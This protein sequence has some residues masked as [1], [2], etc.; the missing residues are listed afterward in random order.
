MPTK[1]LLIALPTTQ[2][3]NL[4]A[5]D[6]GVPGLYEISIKDELKDQPALAAAAA[7]DAFHYRVPVKILDDFSFYVVAPGNG[8][9]IDPPDGV[10]GY[11][12]AEFGLE[13]RKLCDDVP[14]IFLDRD[15]WRRFA[16]PTTKALMQWLPEGF[17]LSEHLEILAEVPENEPAPVR[18]SL[19]P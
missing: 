10:E 16:C 8:D 19:R 5:E 11:A 17:S 12:Y 1:L 2:L 4:D 6:E 9:L 14:R 15:E 13:A 7:L 3:D 18:T